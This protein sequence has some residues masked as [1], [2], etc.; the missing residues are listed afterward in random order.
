[1]NA[2][3]TVALCVYYA[4]IEDSNPIRV[5]NLISLIFYVRKGPSRF[6]KF[7]IWAKY[8]PQIGC[9]LAE[10]ELGAITVNLCLHSTDY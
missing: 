7:A 6:V 5:P 10:L 8:V 4:N 2:Q 1:M 3:T 9:Q